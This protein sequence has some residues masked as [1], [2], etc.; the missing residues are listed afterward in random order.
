MTTDDQKRE[1]IAKHKRVAAWMRRQASELLEQAE[2]HA[3]HAA[4]L[5]AGVE[6]AEPARPTSAAGQEALSRPDRPLGR[7]LLLAAVG[8]AGLLFLWQRQKVT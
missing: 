8:I 5:D 3:Q 7:R 1:L 6:T 2:W 4:R